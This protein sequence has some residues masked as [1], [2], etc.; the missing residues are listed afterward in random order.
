MT[1]KINLRG[2][3]QLQKE[4][5]KFSDKVERLIAEAA[6]NEIVSNALKGKTGIFPFSN[7]PFNKPSTVR[8][9]GHGDR[10]VDKGVLLSEYLWSIRKTG[11]GYAVIPPP[12]RRKIAKY[13]DEK[14]EHRPAYRILYIPKGFFP[15]W[16]TAILKKEF[17]NFLA[18]YQ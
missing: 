15:K 7:L 3:R 12:L 16:A 13:L 18:R 2:L 6:P 4:M 1:V 10:L 11:N 17:N 5:P 14:T 8:K 9:K